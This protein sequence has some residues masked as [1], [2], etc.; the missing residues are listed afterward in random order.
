MAHDWGGREGKWKG[1]REEGNRGKSKAAFRIIKVKQKR[2]FVRPQHIIEA[3]SLNFIN[4]HVANNSS[5][6]KEPADWVQFSSVQSLSRVRLLAT[7]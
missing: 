6:G 7:P 4:I 2:L 3:Q 5:Y 1:G